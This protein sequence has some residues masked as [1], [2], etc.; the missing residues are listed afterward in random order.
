MSVGAISAGVAGSGLP[1]DSW[2]FFPSDHAS[3]GKMI[4]CWVQTCR[5]EL[6]DR[7]LIWNQHHLLNA[8]REFEHFYNQ[9]WPHR[10]LHSAVPLQSLPEPITDPGP[11]ACLY[12]RRRDRLGGTFHEYHHAA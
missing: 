7:T 5:H 1:A 6:L 8:L 2:R 4:C 11:I 3:C 9:H 12:I 10:A